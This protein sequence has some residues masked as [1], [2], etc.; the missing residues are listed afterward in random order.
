MKSRKLLF[1]ITKKD[2][3][4]S[5][6][7]G[8][9]AGG[10]HRNKHANGVRIKH[11]DSGVMVSCNEQR[12]QAQNKR[13]AINRLGKHPD[14][15]KWVKIKAAKMSYNYEQDINKRVADSMRPEH[16]KVEYIGGNDYE[17]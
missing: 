7:R 5:Y 13:V 14:F 15:I 9:G 4:V 12:S 16:L 11:R 1:S 10:Q 6:F 17:N 2:L 8:H 3:D